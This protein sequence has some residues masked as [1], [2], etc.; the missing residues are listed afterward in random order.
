V[1]MRPLPR[2]LHL[3]AYLFMSISAVMS[4]FVPLA[5][6]ALVSW[7]IYIYVWAGS[8]TVGG[9]VGVLGA[10]LRNLGIELGAITLL[11]T[12]YVAYTVVLIARGMILID[13]HRLAEIPGLV[14][15]LFS[16]LALC[17]MLGRRY[18]ELWLLFRHAP[19][20]RGDVT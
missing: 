5:S 4:F 14:Y 13:D 8:L 12:G 3:L 20:V 19:R 15:V 7:K 11:L 17:L 1:P 9:L 6:F 10:S 2:W 16:T 18:A